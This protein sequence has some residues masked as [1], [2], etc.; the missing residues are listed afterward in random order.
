MIKIVKFRVVYEVMSLET[1][2]HPIEMIVISGV[3]LEQRLI[4]HEPAYPFCRGKD[5]LSEIFDDI[6]ISR[7]NS[8]RTYTVEK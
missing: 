8:K 1:T 7:T 5:F 4:E 6:L 2:L 3:D